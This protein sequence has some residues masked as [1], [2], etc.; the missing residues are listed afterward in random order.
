MITSYDA[1]SA[2]IRDLTQMAQDRTEIAGEDSS[3]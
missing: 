2:M 1:G 3:I